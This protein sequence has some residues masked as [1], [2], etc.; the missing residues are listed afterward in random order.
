MPDWT[1]CHLCEGKA[2]LLQLDVDA[3]QALFKA[4]L[5]R[6]KSSTRAA[7]EMQESDWAIT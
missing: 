6:L 1:S 7:L 4:T 2:G 3:A 5:T